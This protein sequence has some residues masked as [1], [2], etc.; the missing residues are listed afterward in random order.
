MRE[1]GAAV[2]VA[3]QSQQLTLVDKQAELDAE[4]QLLK[5]RVSFDELGKLAADY[6]IASTRAM[7]MRTCKADQVCYPF[8]ASDDGEAINDIPTYEQVVEAFDDC[9]SVRSLLA[10]F[11]TDCDFL[12]KAE[13]SE[14]T[15]EPPTDGGAAEEEAEQG[16][17]N[18]D[19]LPGPESELPELAGVGAGDGLPFPKL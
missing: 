12:P 17:A 6:V 13:T 11:L 7:E 15:E 5:L 1:V 18:E 2:H 14:G 4:D 3:I 10:I 19:D 9:D 16:D 8:P